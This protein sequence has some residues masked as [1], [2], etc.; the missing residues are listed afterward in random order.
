MSLNFKRNI[1]LL[2][3]LIF[4]LGF[5]SLVLGNQRVIAYT[6]KSGSTRVDHGVIIENDIALFDDTVVHEIQLIMANSD[7]TTMI[8]T[9]QNTGE[10]DFFHADVIIDGVR[11]NNVGVRLKGNASLRTVL[12]GRGNGEMG[13][14]MP[15]GRPNMGPINGQ[16]IATLPQ[17]LNGGMPPDLENG[18]LPQAPPDG[19]QNGGRPDRWQQRQGGENPNGG[20]QS[21]GNSSS[22]EVIPPLLFRFDKY[23]E[24]QTYQDYTEIA[25]RTW[26]TSSDVS[27]LQEPLTNT[28]ATMVGLPATKTA[29]TSFQRNKGKTS[30]LTISEVID[31]TYLQRFFPGS[32]GVLYKAAFGARMTYLG[33]DPSLYVASFDQQTRVNDADAA[34]LIAFL[35]FLDQ[36]TDEEFEQNLP[37][38]LDVD[39]FAAYLALNNLLPGFY[40]V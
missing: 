37:K 31:E 8:S 39:A 14:M 4:V 34:Q 3:L 40:I 22:E 13:G 6:A 26:G 7:Y 2:L 5:F 23:E 33:E 28:A 21:P 16:P 1:P 20:A 19:G 10:K 18:P 27:M 29:Y 38:Y 36:A 11:V 25:I 35:K 32:N 24:G 30:L 15:M 9:Y 17:E 12:G